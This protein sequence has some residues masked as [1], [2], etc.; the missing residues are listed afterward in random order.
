[1]EATL[2]LAKSGIRFR[3]ALAELSLPPE[4]Q[5]EL[6]EI[7]EEAVEAATD[8]GYNGAMRSAEIGEEAALA[9]LTEFADDLCD[10]L[11]PSE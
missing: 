7:V 10:T 6:K 2:K 9:E 8:L 1:M 5:A 3:K 4:V 11:R